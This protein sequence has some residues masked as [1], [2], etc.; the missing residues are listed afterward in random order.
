MLDI[1]ANYGEVALYAASRVGPSGTVHAFEPN[2]AICSLLERS[3]A[4]NGFANLHVHQVALGAEDATGEMAAP[5][6]NT[7]AASLATSCR[8]DVHFVPV[9]IR[10]AA[11]Y[12]K[13]LNLASLAVVKLDVEGMEGIILDTLETE[14]RRL[15]PR[16]IVFESKQEEGAFFGR[17]SV[18]C[19]K[20]LG[21]EFQQVSIR[22]QL[23]SLVRL[24]AIHNDDDVRDGYDFVAR[25]PQACPEA[26][27]D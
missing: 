6:G 13:G 2:P 10:D 19:L 26:G 27:Q 16:L 22:R 9:E 17:R 5:I 8:P 7:G 12:V 3:A 4:L 18:Q 23:G 25:L 20:R 15:R 11:Q 21:Y 24:I 1:G 14:L